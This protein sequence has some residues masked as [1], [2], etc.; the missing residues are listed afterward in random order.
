ME[1]QSFAND[2][3]QNVSDKTSAWWVPVRARFSAIGRL[4]QMH[5]E[6]S[7][8]LPRRIDPLVRRMLPGQILRIKRAE[9]CL[10]S[11][12]DP[13]DALFH[14][15]SKKRDPKIAAREQFGAAH[16]GRAS[17][18]GGA[19]KLHLFDRRC[20]IVRHVAPTRVVVVLIHPPVE[21]ALCKGW[22]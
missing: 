18:M 6:E 11:G 2:A 3:F 20:S 14:A 7:V 13:Y 19:I 16:S 4:V 12:P 1:F 15:W 8:R 10:D 17:G 22:M 21:R 9:R 5:G